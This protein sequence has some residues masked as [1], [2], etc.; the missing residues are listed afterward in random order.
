MEE[1][2]KN[3]IF[4]REVGGNFPR[5]IGLSL[6]SGVNP[7]EAFGVSPYAIVTDLYIRIYELM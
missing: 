7:D 3:N 6:L 5:N 1:G 4:T 2:I